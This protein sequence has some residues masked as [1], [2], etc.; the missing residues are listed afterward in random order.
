MMRYLFILFSL[1]ILAGTAGAILPPDASA[2]EPQI[3]AQ[4]VRLREQYEKRLV[5]RQAVAVRAYEQTRS[6]IFIPPWMRTGA[7]TDVPA[8]AVAVADGKTAKA[9]KRNYRFLISAV[10]LILTGI[11]AGW[12]RYATRDTDR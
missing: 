9:A 4:R 7:R 11:L 5:D 1:V 3:R 2:R 8:S 6:D 12:V 10:L